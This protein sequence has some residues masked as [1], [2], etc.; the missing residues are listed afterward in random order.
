VLRL[1]DASGVEGSWIA[2][3]ETLPKAVTELLRLAGD[4]YLPYLAANNQAFGHGET[5]VVVE[6]TGQRYA[7]VPFRYQVKCYDGLRRKF[8][9]LTPDAR[10]RIEPVLAETGCLRWLTGGAA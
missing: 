9:S 1:D 7:Q 10:K 4:Y 2:P 6:L 3:T 5:E 8:A